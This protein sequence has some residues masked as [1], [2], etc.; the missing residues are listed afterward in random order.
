MASAAD[1]GGLRS[2][3]DIGLDGLIADALGLGY[4]QT[5]DPGLG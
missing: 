3:M 1:Q 5:I 4:R 2:V